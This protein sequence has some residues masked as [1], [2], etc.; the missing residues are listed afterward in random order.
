MKKVL[1]FPASNL[2]GQETLKSLAY[3]THLEAVPLNTTED[4]PITVDVF[5]KDWTRQMVDYVE[6]HPVDAIL[7]THD[8]AIFK[9]LSSRTLQRLM[10]QHGSLFDT[11]RHKD[12]LYER[13]ASV[14]IPVPTVYSVNRGLLDMNVQK[15]PGARVCI[16]PIKGQGSRGVRFNLNDSSGDLFYDLRSGEMETSYLEGDEYTLDCFTRSDGYTAVR[17]RKR[18][19][20]KNGL[21]VHTESV[22]VSNEHLKIAQEIPYYLHLRGAWFFQVKGGRVIDIGHRIAGA[23]SINRF[24]GCNLTLLS[25]YQ[26]FGIS[27]EYRCYDWFHSVKDG[28]PLGNIKA[29]IDIYVDLDDVLLIGG[30]WNKKLLLSLFKA[31]LAGAKLTIITRN[32]DLPTILN[33]SHSLVA[34]LFS[35][36]FVTDSYSK[37]DLMEPYGMFIDDS[38]S[39]RVK[40]L[41]KLPCLALD[42][43]TGIEVLE[44]IYE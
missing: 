19:E 5:H 44:A 3:N 14:G 12:T 23:S 26:F 42:V 15:P 8:E 13:L 34:P 31:K 20:I 11:V 36:A 10:Y 32:T 41:D 1:V 29:L 16:K 24:N 27:A 43:Q 22:V 6:S 37:A 38:W 30:E 25:L 4:G 21:A 18:V 9:G 39:E 40:V 28:K 2:V 35:N 7:F 17:A 33:K